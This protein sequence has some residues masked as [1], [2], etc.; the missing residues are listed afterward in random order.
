MVVGL[1]RLWPATSQRRQ[2]SCDRFQGRSGPLQAGVGPAQADPDRRAD[3]GRD[4]PR[5][6]T[7]EADGRTSRGGHAGRG[8]GHAKQPRGAPA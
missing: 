8:S 4:A 6:R 1:Q 7:A 3:R 5:G 2:R